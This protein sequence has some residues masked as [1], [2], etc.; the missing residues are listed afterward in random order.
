MGI[1]A[2]VGHFFQ[3]ILEVIQ[4]IFAAIVNTFLFALSTV[5]DAGKGVVH[6]VE[7]TLGFAFRKFSQHDT[8]APGPRMSRARVLQNVDLL[9]ADRR[10]DNFFIIGTITAAV[11][12]YLLYQQRQGTTPVGKAVKNK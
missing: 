10:L 1:A 7:G 12:G 5:A 3:S 8:V 4:G 9:F 2:G 11:F 6:F